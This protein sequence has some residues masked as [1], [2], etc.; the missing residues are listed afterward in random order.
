MKVSV[1]LQSSE[2]KRRRL[3]GTLKERYIWSDMVLPA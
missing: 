3:H 2:V 1:D